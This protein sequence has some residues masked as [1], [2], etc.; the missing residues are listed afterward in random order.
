MASDHAHRPINVIRCALINS[1][2]LKRLCL[3]LEQDLLLS[4]RRNLLTNSSTP[5][6]RSSSP[7]P[8]LSNN[9]DAKLFADCEYEVYHACME[10]HTGNYYAVQAE[11]GPRR[12]QCSRAS[13]YLQPVPPPFVC[14]RPVQ[15][16]P[17]PPYPPAPSPDYEAD[18]SESR[19]FYMACLQNSYAACRNCLVGP[20]SGDPVPECEQLA[21]QCDAATRGTGPIPP[22]YACRN[23]PTPPPPP[24]RPP[25][26]PPQAGQPDHLTPPP[27]RTF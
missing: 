8:P 21:T 9:Y 26:A 6:P 27:S 3:G 24:P 20:L 4:L 17:R 5:G 25:L 11:C 23:F 16:G 18:R 22:P 10:C 1:R 19:R 14:P 7:Q 15:R 2:L 12:E 13:A